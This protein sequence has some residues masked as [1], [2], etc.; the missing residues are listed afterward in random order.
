[1]MLLTS[2]VSWALDAKA[3]TV[4]PLDMGSEQSVRLLSC[5]YDSTYERSQWDDFDDR[6]AVFCVLSVNFHLSILALPSSL[7][8]YAPRA[9]V[10]RAARPEVCLHSLEPA[11]RLK[12]D[13]EKL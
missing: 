11:R 12:I 7:R 5:C 4:D 2:I 9:Y 10:F 1:M 8:V 6:V 3:V 13:A